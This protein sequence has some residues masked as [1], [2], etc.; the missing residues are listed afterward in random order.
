LFKGTVT[1]VSVKVNVSMILCSSSVV[2]RVS[3][4]L[5]LPKA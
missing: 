4:L 5:A 2:L 3:P 1:C